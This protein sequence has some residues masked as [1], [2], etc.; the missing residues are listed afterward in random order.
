MDTKKAQREDETKAA[1]PSSE[2][3][4]H[5]PA[6]IA[7]RVAEQIVLSVAARF[8]TLY[9]A[10]FL[11][12]AGLLLLIAWQFGPLVLLQAHAYR[13]MTGHVDARIV[14]SWLALEFD[15]YSMRVPSN[16]RAETHAARC[17]VVEYEGDWGAPLR[18][19]FCGTRVPFNQSYGLAELDDISPGVPFAWARDEHGF[20][21]P[22]IR[23]DA[24]TLEWL[25]SHA[26]DKF[27]HPQWPAKTLL[28]DLRLDLDRPVDAAV[29]GWAAKPPVVS[30]TFDPARPAEA[31]PAGIV[32]K[33]LAQQPNWLVMAMGFVVG[34]VVWFKAMAMLPLL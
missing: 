29:N 15:G 20:V 25:G 1:A 33:R 6:A 32:V 9:A 30:L 2:P 4:S 12:F 10:L 17:E 18:R 22:E 5:S 24:R 27:M 28:D 26:H 11:A 21:V 14:E 23:L 31:L 13:K 7:R 8:G 16:W 19:A 3:S 34:G